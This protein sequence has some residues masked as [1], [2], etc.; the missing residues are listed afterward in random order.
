MS[1]QKDLFRIC[2]YGNIQTFSE[3]KRTVNSHIPSQGFDNYQDPVTFALC[4]TF[5]FS[6]LQHFRSNC[7]PYV[8]SPVHEN[9]STYSSKNTRHFLHNCNAIFIPDKRI[10]C[11]CYYLITQ[12][13]SNLSK[14]H[15]KHT[16]QN[17]YKIYVWNLLVW[18]LSLWYQSSSPALVIFLSAYLQQ[19]GQF[20][21]EMWIFL[22]PVVSFNLFL[23]LPYFL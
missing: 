15:Q 17:A 20:S 23:S 13:K 10:N 11:S 22:L 5:C 7:R 3:V 18:L 8:I 19:L 6:L 14:R 2:P 4:T 16:T 9:V 1:L 21:C 12:P